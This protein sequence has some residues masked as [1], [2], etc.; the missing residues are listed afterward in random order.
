MPDIVDYAVELD[1]TIYRQRG[2]G[3][4]LLSPDVP[5]TSMLPRN[6]EHEFPPRTSL[7]TSPESTSFISSLY[8]RYTEERLLEPTDIPI[9]NPVPSVAPPVEGGVEDVHHADVGSRDWNSTP[10]SNDRL[11]RMITLP[12]SQVTTQ[13]ATAP[14]PTP[15]LS[16]SDAST[17]SSPSPVSPVD[18][19]VVKVLKVEEQECDWFMPSSFTRSSKRAAGG[20]SAPTAKKR[21]SSAKSTTPLSRSGATRFPCSVPGCKQVCKTLGDLKR[22][23]SVLSHKPPSWKCNR[24]GYRFTREDA[25]KRHTRNLPKCATTKN[26]L[27]GRA[28]STKVQRPEDVS[29]VEAI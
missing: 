16:H 18:T 4:I 25:L 1:N 17:I 22:H 27:R 8:T 29:S 19:D 10:P 24:C 12:L 15:S 3:S 5:F 13:V 7:F 20:R 11:T 21:S 2:T 28:A 14:S 23:E 9:F 26:N 6:G